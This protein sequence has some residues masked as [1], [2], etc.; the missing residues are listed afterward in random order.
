[1]IKA[2]R[3]LAFSYIKTPSAVVGVIEPFSYINQM[4]AVSFS[5]KLS[6]DLTLEDIEAWD[7]IICIRGAEEI[8]LRI[9]QHAKKLDRITIYYMDDDLLN[10]SGIYAFNQKYY[11]NEKTKQMISNIMQLSDVLWTNN[12]I[13]AQKFGSQ[14]KHTLVTEAPATL[15]YSFKERKRNN[16]Y[17][18]EEEGYN[19]EK[20]SCITIG[21]SGG[22]DHKNFFQTLL[23]KPYVSV[24]EKYQEKVKFEIVGFAPSYLNGLPVK[25]YPYITDYE[26]Y[27]CFMSERKWDIAVAPLNSSQFNSCKYYNKFLEYGA[28]KAAGIYSDVYPFREIVKDKENGLLAENNHLSWERALYTLIEGEEFRA[29]IA[30]NAYNTLRTD[31]CIDM[32]SEDILTKLN[33]LIKEVNEIGPVS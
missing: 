17:C 21:F 24:Y 14:F 12:K 27:R 26:Q 28:I 31:F 2:L 25:V 30:K 32:V 3:V 6:A 13:I 22:I 5:F 10:V 9:M 23:K 11:Q 15:L 16:G 4:G 8:D 18:V 33:K 20:N 1:M 29:E 7:V 19:S